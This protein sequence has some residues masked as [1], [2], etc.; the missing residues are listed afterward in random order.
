MH[1]AIITPTHDVRHLPDCARSIL[2]QSERG[3][4]EISWWVGLNNSARGMPIGETM[5][6]MRDAGFDGVTVLNLGTERKIGALKRA[7]FDAAFEGG[8]DVVIELDHDDVLHRYAVSSVVAAVED[9]AGFV[10]SDFAEFRDGTAEPHTY[11]AEYGWRAYT[12]NVDAPGTSIH[13]T[14][15]LAMRAFAPSAR[16]MCQILYAPNHLRAWTRDAYRAAGG[17]DPALD[18]CDDHDLLV[19]TY[20][21]G[22]PMQHVAACLYYYRLGANTYSGRLNAKIQALSG[23]GVETYP[24]GS[25]VPDFAARVEIRD[26]HLHDLVVEE[27]R[28]RGAHNTSRMLDLG[29]GVG[30]DPSSPWT[31]VDLS[32]GHVRRDLRRGLP[33]ADGSVVAIRAF[34]VLE[35]LDP[36]DAAF[37]VGE[38]WRVLANGGWLLTRTPADPGVGASCDLSHK[39]RWNTRSW[40]YFWA[41][42]LRPYRD[43]AFP[44][45]VQPSAHAAPFAMFK[46]VRVLTETVT[47]G[48]APCRWDVLYVVADLLVDKSG[49]MPGRAYW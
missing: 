39:S 32:N 19:R 8:A 29:G 44:M 17:H 35:H 23:M 14:G 6:E 33:Y 3:S 21:S 37:L 28:R 7:L 30:R 24:D 26:R 40:A 12:T 47:M 45:L 18:V 20:L 10:Y 13:G 9:G 11:S 38:C 27:C 42:Q 25:R 41:G 1:V 15:L 46:P 36:D 43:A 2:A 22:V 31:V 49:T 16:S 4:A 34:D 48:P 5:D